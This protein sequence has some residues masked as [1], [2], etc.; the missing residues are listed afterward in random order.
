MDFIVTLLHPNKYAEKGHEWEPAQVWFLD[1]NYHESMFAM[2]KKALLIGK[3]PG[4]FSTFLL[5]PF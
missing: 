3:L 2:F 1:H 5:R 4:C